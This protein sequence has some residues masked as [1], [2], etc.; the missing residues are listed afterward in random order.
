MP[1]IVDHEK[2][3]AEIAA[4]LWRVI[5]REGIIGISIRAVAKEAG[6]PKATVTYY[7]NTQG[8]L[9]TYAMEES[10][11]VSQQKIAKILQNAP[12]V[13]E[14]VEALLEAIPTTPL[15]R[16]QTSIWLEVITQ[17]QGNPDLRRYLLEVNNT[18]YLAVCAILEQMRAQGL[19]SPRRSIE[20]E[21]RTLHA[22]IDGLSLHTMT[23]HRVTPPAQI[24]EIATHLILQLQQ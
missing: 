8:D 24:R 4:A 9:L 15:R 11:R 6:Y 12:G 13:P 17:A 21:A 22:V 18:V 7:F 16:R 14:Y 23:S 2:R 10:L 1:K 3:R 19:M 20:L 5:Q